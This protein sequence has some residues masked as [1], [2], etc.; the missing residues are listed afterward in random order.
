MHDIVLEPLAGHVLRCRAM[1]ASKSGHH[2]TPEGLRMMP[3]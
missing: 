1:T 3:A 2:R